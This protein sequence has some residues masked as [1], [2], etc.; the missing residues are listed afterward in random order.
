LMRANPMLCQAIK[1][2]DADAVLAHVLQFFSAALHPNP[3]RRE[4]ETNNV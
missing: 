2:Q 3:A 4:N 1:L